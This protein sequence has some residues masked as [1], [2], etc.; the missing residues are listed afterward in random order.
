M[1]KEAR[2][3]LWGW[4]QPLKEAGKEVS[5][6]GH[7]SSHHTPPDTA[8]HTASLCLQPEA[9]ASSLPLTQMLSSG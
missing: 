4:G 2:L 8:V 3:G 9:A 7:P 6:L 1:S 5:L